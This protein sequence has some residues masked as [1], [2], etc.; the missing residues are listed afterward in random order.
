MPRGEFLNAFCSENIAKK[1][2]AGTP[3]FYE[4]SRSRGAFSQKKKSFPKLNFPSFPSDFSFP[5]FA[6]FLKISE[7]KTQKMENEFSENFLQRFAGIA[8]LYGVPALRKLKNSHVAIVG[9]GGVGS[10]ACEALSRSGIGKITLADVDEISLTN[11]NRQLHALDGNFGRAKI[12]AMSERLRA[13]NP[14]AEISSAKVFIDEKSAG[15][16]FAEGGIFS[17]CDLLVDAIDGAQNKAA[18]IAAAVSAGT[19][20]VSS[21]G[22]AGKR[23]GTRIEVSDLAFAENDL[24]LKFVKKTLRARFGFPKGGKKFGVPA[25]FSREISRALSAEEISGTSAGTS[26][27]AASSAVVVP[28]MISPA[29]GKPRAG[30]AS[31]VTGAFGL[32]LAELAIS[33]L[34]EN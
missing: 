21:G 26:V 4:I 10:W 8:R 33:R 22:C 29:G 9:L 18:L 28:E 14:E 15:T 17:R 11:A 16:F 3:I 34:L 2:R 1:L 6:E 30:T 19:K 24:L 12:D 23:S 13:I 7:T 32:A 20:I 25:V 27:E 5:N 31:F